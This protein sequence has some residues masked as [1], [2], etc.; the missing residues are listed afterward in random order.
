MEYRTNVRWKIA[1]LVVLGL[2]LAPAASAQEPTL[3]LRSPT[4]SAGHVAFV[5]AGD[6]WIAGR[7]GQHPRRLTVHSGLEQDPFL[8]P[9]GRWVAFTGDYDGNVDVFVG[10]VEGGEPR[11]LTFHPGSDRVRGWTADGA[12]MFRTT[13]DSHTYR[14][15]HL[16][17]VTT[18]GAFPQA[19][20]IPA[21]ERAAMSADG[22]SIAYTPARDAFQTWKRYR[23]GRTTPVWIFDLESHSIEEIPHLNAS[24]TNPIWD[25]GRV[26][27]LSDREGVMNLYV[28]T[29]RG[30]AGVRR[31]TQHEDFDIKCAAAHGGAVVYEQAGRLH[32]LVLQTGATRPLPIVI[33]TDLPQLRPHFEDAA[34]QIRSIGLSPTGVR[35]LVGARGDVFTVPAEHGNIR[36]VTATPGV[37]ERF[38]AWS[39]D[40]SQ[41]AYLSDAAGEYALHI[42]P[43][44]GQGQPRVV[45]LGDE[46]FYYAPIWS[47]D[48]RSVAYTDKRL[49]LWVMDLDAERPVRVDTEPYDE[50][51]RTMEPVWSPD[52]RWLA[53]ARRL[54]SHL[55]A[56]FLYDTVAGRTTQITDG[57]SDAVDPAFS[58]DGKALFFA[59]STNLAL[60]TGWLDMTSY[61]RPVRRSLYLAVLAAGEPSPLAPR[62]DEEVVGAPE[63]EGKKKKG[64]K[65]CKG[66]GED[67]AEEPVVVTVDLEGIDQRILAVPVPEGDYRDLK[68]AE[69][70]LFYLAAGDDGTALHRFDLEER[71]S[72][73]L[74]TDTAG[75]VVS[76][77]GNKVLHAASGHVLRI[78]DAT[79]D[80]DAAAAVEP[81]DLTAMRNYVDPRAEFEQI[82]EEAWRIQRDYF[83]DPGMHGVDWAA[84]REQYRPW[85]AHVGHRDD[86][87]Y[88]IGETI[89]ELTVGH[90]Y[91][92]GGDYPEV[93]R[94]DGG[95]LGADLVIEQGH[96]RFQRILGG[97]NWDPEQR[98][99]LT[100]PGVDVHEG[101]YLL[102]VNG[103]PLDAGTNPH[104]LF[105]NTAGIQTA[106]TVNDRP[107][108]TGAR[109]VTVVPIGDESGLRYRDWVEGNRRRVDEAT[110]GRVA[111]VHMPNTAWDGYTAFNRYFYAQLD[112]EAVIL[113]ERHNGGGSVADY[114]VDML[115][116]QALNMNVTREG[117]DYSSP[118]GVIDG[119]KVMI[120]NEDAGSGGDCMPHYFRQMGLGKLVGTRTWGG[121]I[122]IYDYPPLIDGGMVTAPRIAF[123][124]P[125]GEWT[126]ENIG[127]APDIEVEMTPAE[128]IAGR[129]PQL[130]KA[131]EVIL[132]ELAASPAQPMPRP[133]FPDYSR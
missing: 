57:M 91:R 83:Y 124:G 94:L 88:L 101:D 33:Q 62:S 102:A 2:I 86:L 5:Y 40:G 52:S 110:A 121:L 15:G 46:S 38:P 99:P 77:D 122:G 17:V 45:Q 109:Q 107:T 18:E 31:L 20:P 30:A 87:N 105:Q 1:L 24:D 106:L 93:E 130:E 90:A 69:G 42:E 104:E 32:E 108:L 7:D 71:E 119:P 116:R 81:L 28:F 10:P 96:Y 112:K 125:E 13:R 6:I 50:P 58:R 25:D 64:K 36:N 72:K 111:Y 97:L 73:A 49:N 16:F 80:A 14:S 67:D 65:G 100:E 85:L 61:E 54:D 128:V 3:L 51:P 78:L 95:L 41:I 19:L 9:D 43:Q 92:W 56:I 113:D 37:H 12:V 11:R 60:R 89:G 63:E 127:V 120:I 74:M 22:K 23:G 129:D 47:P 103:V 79:A 70:A 84:V 4:V 53:Y 59:A 133:P 21:V 115:A 131:I 126:A 66:G 29:P 34:G 118:L 39:P 123:Y 98:A 76:A 75:Y 55:H 26:L 48:S 8:S 82:Y 35:V 114:V 132:E 117:A 68:T 27:F 44:D